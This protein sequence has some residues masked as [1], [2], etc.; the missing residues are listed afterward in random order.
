MKEIK[1][2][3]ILMIFLTLMPL[4]AQAQ[5]EGTMKEELDSTVIEIEERILLFQ[6]ELNQIYA[7]TRFQINIDMEMPLTEPLLNAVSGRLTSL[8]N[9]LNS[10]KVRWSTYSQAQQVYLA[11]NDT[12]LNQT[13]MIEQAQQMVT[14]TLALRQQQF[15][16]LNAFTKAEKF[17]WGQDK[18]YRQLYK[19]AAQY[20]LS[21]KLAS[22]LEKVKAEEATLTSELQTSYDQAK[23]A[24]ESFPGLDL[25]MQSMEKKYVELQS[26]SA[27]IQAMEYKPIIQRIK[28][29][30]IGLAA[31]A[32]LMM[33]VNLFSQKLKQLK[34]LRDQAKKM[35]E[36]MGGHHEYPTI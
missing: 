16:Q 10:F 32:I 30:L 2:L 27:K 7:L 31:V 35:K 4:T 29:Y 8:T 20:S 6:E 17:I 33:F 25:R 26:V 21:P 23:A 34:Q 19:Q 1:S 14:D 12:L 22:K 24:A 3:L 36:A 9:A 13:A 11:D 28:D 18:K 15:D 5:E